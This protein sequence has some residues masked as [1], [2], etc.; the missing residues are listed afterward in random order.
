M[1][2]C[3]QE[4]SSICSHALVQGTIIIIIGPEAGQTKQ[5]TVGQQMNKCLLEPTQRS[6]GGQIEGLFG[7]IVVRPLSYS[8]TPSIIPHN[9]KN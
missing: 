2:H 5:S 6:R 8:L 4:I 3:T 1:R 9:N 7:Q